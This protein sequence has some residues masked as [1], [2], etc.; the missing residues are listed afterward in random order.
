MIAKLVSNAFW[1]SYEK[2]VTASQKKH[3]ETQA[4]LARTDYL[5]HN[6]NSIF[7]IGK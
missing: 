6:P 3:Q 5:T 2:R 4:V 1:N 7:Y